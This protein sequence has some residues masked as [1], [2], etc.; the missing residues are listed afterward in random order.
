M[1]AG[2][3]DLSP[4]E[5]QILNLTVLQGLSPFD[6]NL[7]SSQLSCLLNMYASTTWNTYI[8]LVLI[9]LDGYTLV[10]LFGAYSEHQ[11]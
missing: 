2:F 7:Q 4:T 11:C 1:M 5:S 3:T 10:Q 8:N 9:E 6:K